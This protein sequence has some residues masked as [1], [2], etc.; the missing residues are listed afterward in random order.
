M[1][2]QLVETCFSGD[3]TLLDADL[4]QAAYVK[5]VLDAAQVTHV[6]SQ[7]EQGLKLVNTDIGSKVSERYETLINNVQATHAVEGKMLRS[8]ERIDALSNTVRR[9]QS[10]C[11]RPFAKLQEGTAQLNRMHECAELLRQV[12]RAVVLC[13]R[14]R[15]SMA[16]PAPRTSAAAAPATPAVMA[17]A[18]PG[19]A[20]TPATAMACSSP[21]AT[22]APARRADLAKA[23]AALHDLEEILAATDLSGIDV[24][25][26]ERDYIAASAVTIRE[27]AKS[28]LS[29][30]VAAQSQAQVGA[31]L[32]IFYNLRELQNASVA[33]AA[34]VA[35]AF[36]A[37]VAAGLDAAT[38]GPDAAFKASGG[39]GVLGDLGG[40][41]V[42]NGM[43]PASVAGS[44]RSALWAK[45][46][47][48][49]ETF[50]VS[51]LR[52]ADL[53]RVLG[54]KRDPL[55]HTLF[56][57]TFDED[58]AAGAGA[59]GQNGMPTSGHRTYC[60]DHPGAVDAR[61]ACADVTSLEEQPLLRCILDALPPEA[62]GTAVTDSKPAAT[63]AVAG[64][65]GAPFVAPG[66]FA[67]TAPGLLVLWAPLARGLQ[68]SFDKAVAAAPFVRQTLSKEL[69]QLVDLLLSAAERAEQH[70]LPVPLPAEAQAA[71]CAEAM[72]EGL[73]VLRD[74]YSRD[75]AS[76]LNAVCEA[77]LAQ[78][79]QGAAATA[80]A[81]LGRAVA[82]ELQ[83]CRGL[84][85]IQRLVVDAG[86]SA[87][88][89]FAL[90]AEQSALCRSPDGES[91]SP[92]PAPPAGQPTSRLERTNGDLLVAIQE[93]RV[94]I[95]SAL[96]EHVS[97]AVGA[98]LRG[99][100]SS[101]GAVCAALANPSTPLPEE[102]RLEATS[103]LKSILRKEMIDN[104]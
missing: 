14:L 91:A 62:L 56:A 15:E 34:D 31:A 73:A 104:L 57:S 1:A 50:F 84:D 28:L 12:Q 87:V 66:L 5:T 36:E 94:D 97:D 101:L 96:D 42:R 24:I 82:R 89:L 38:F 9:I 37:S 33:A 83:Q 3:A 55:S 60:R 7:L 51:A 10:Q 99:A 98:P 68:R 64:A 2:A 11:A 32:Q 69:P 58:T 48:V 20:A 40:G 65:V 45:L 90:Q 19:A 76:T 21:S 27:Q 26:A 74:V 41:S 16:P 49:A 43:P 102:C 22:A 4:D 80:S 92:A 86:A 75:L 67:G 61:W 85:P 53:Q 63:R 17:S 13:K 39:G 8:S 79:G 30:G 46:D 72:V 88:R 54:K 71:L 29:S 6:Q 103:L 18:S 95:H 44:W 35:G 59:G 78:L 23:A 81:R 77:Q 70:L 47:G 52:I 93:L 100:L 25:D